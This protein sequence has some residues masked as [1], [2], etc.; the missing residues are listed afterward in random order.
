V[1]RFVTTVSVMRLLTEA[2]ASLIR[3]GHTQQARTDLIWNGVIDWKESEIKRPELST[4]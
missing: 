2:I 4:N 1:L 3:N